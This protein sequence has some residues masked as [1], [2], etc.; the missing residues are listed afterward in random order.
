MR[1]VYCRPMDLPNRQ[2]ILLGILLVVTAPVAIAQFET[3]SVLGTIRDTS[4]AV[5]P[6]AAVTLTNTRT[7]AV[8]AT[9]TDIDGNYEFFNVRIGEYTVRASAPGF[10]TATANPF[11]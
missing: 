10:A 6:N 7:S 1:S 11:A 4:G 3:A 2:L 9:K 5:V 8:A